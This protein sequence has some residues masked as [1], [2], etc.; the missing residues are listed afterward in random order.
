MDSFTVSSAQKSFASRD[1]SD[2]DKE[3]MDAALPNSS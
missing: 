2:G 3:V 1:F